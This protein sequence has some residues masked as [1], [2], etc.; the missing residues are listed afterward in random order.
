MNEQLTSSRD[1]IRRNRILAALA[2]VVLL[3][4]PL[5]AMT[6]QTGTMT[7]YLG[8]GYPPGQGTYIMMRIAGHLAY[9]LV[10]LQIVIGLLHRPLQRR[11][12]LGPL[13]PVHRSLGLAGFI[14]A[15]SH[16]VLFEWA[17]QLRTGQSTVTVTFW[18]P[19]DTGFYELHQFFGAMGLYLLLIGVL[20]GV[21]G[22]R[23]APR[24]WRTVHMLNYAVFFL[25]WYHSLR[26]G[27]S[28]RIG[29]LPILYTVL[30]AVVV[31]LT[32][33]RLR[34][35]SAPQVAVPA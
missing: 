24:A 34:R 19:T 2:V 22:P 11:L 33:W 1:E 30:A 3:L 27:T 8:Q 16:P 15:L 21:F 20:A 12:G 5:T 18:P 14:L 29:A 31:G 23:L 13:L 35:R 9:T 7:Y 6:S 32:L 26:I 10:F 17:R 4:V 28:T 25:V